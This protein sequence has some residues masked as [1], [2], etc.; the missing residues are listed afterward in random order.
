MTEYCS[1]ISNCQKYLQIIEKFLMEKMVN[2]CFM[3]FPGSKHPSK[4]EEKKNFL[5]TNLQHREYPEPWHH[6][7]SFLFPILTLGPCCEKCSKLQARVCL[8]PIQIFNTQHLFKTIQETQIK[9]SNS[10]LPGSYGA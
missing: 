5:I 7:V 8:V 9:P 3:V 2:Y 6:C 1:I 4:R 10:S